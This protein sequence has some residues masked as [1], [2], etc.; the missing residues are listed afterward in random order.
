[1][2]AVLVLNVMMLARGQLHNY[3]KK[4]SFVGRVIYPRTGIKKKNCVREE[5][6]VILSIY[7]CTGTDAWTWESQ[8]VHPSLDVNDW[9]YRKIFIVSVSVNL[10]LFFLAGCWL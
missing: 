8:A 7:I 5:L 9:I 10:P 2:A 1:M 3:E 6:Q 4:S